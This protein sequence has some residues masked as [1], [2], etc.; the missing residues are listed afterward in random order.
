MRGQLSGSFKIPSLSASGSQASPI[1]SLSASSCPEFGTYG[2]LS[3]LQRGFVQ[4]K[5]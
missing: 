2:Q 5:S 4:A 3:F 1:S